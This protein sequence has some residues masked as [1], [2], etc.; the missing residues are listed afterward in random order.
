MRVWPVRLLCLLLPACAAA[1]SGCTPVRWERQ[2]TDAATQ[3]A[4]I[5]VCRGSA[6][7][8]YRTVNEDPLLIPYFVTVRDNN[9]RTRE[10]PIVPSRQFSPPVWFANAPRLALDHLS[11]RQQ[12]FEQCLLSKGYRTVPDEP[13]EPE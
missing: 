5:R 2:Q 7:R 9:G 10:I 8:A 4:D 13:Q 12:F 6:H 1:L 11:L 3:E